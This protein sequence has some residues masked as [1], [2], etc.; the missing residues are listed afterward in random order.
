MR[1]LALAEALREA[2]A[3][4]EFACRKGDGL[5]S[6]LITAQGFAV[7]GLPSG[8]EDAE[9]T[10]QVAQGRFD[11]AIV[12]QYEL[13]APWERRARTFARRILAVD[14]LADRPHDADLLLDQNYYANLWR[15][16]A[17]L[18]SPSCDCL[19]GPAYALLRPQFAAARRKRGARDGTVRR[20]LVSFGA[21]DAMQQTA[22]AMEALRGLNLKGIEID[23]A[24]GRSSAEM[25]QLMA[26]ADF[27]LGSGGVSTNERMCLGLPAAVVATHP[28]QE[29]SARDVAAIGAHRYLGPASALDPNRYAAA[30]VELLSEPAAL[31]KMSEEGMRQVDGLG[32]RRVVS[33]MLAG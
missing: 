17:G 28:L 12:D 33:R 1:Q 10:Q 31:R 19:L 29:S 27:A 14:D 8:V 24:T 26:D 4:V 18:V 9:A 5:A 11:W 13:G 30:V 6:K 3:A 7:H 22:V 25:A 16:Y 23:I 32:T 20:I 2:G 21:T 15:R